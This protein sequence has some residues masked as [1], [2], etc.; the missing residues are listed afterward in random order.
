MKALQISKPGKWGEETFPR[1]SHP[2]SGRADAPVQVR[3]RRRQL[4]LNAMVGLLLLTPLIFGALLGP[5]IAPYPADEMN[6]G[7]RLHAPSS[8]YPFGTD[9]FGRDLFSRVLTG[10]RTAAGMALGGIAISTLLGT[11]LGLLAGYYGGW[12][13]HLLS[14]AMDTWLAFPGL[15][16]AIIIVAR[17]GPSLTN[18]IIALGFMEVPVLYRV[19]RG[20]TLSVRHALYVEA[21]RAIGMTDRR[22]LT[23]HILPDLYSPITVLCTLHMGT[24]LLA[25]SGLSFIGLGAQPPQPEWG[26]LLSSGRRYMAQAWWLTFFPGMAIML[27][28][29]GFNLLG[30][31]LRDLLDPRLRTRR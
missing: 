25:G 30:D 29:L 21:A 26:L 20:T 19:A 8:Q 24:I 31:G 14:R 22:L 13:D 18:A 28:V 3:R 12:L 7:P 4:P 1:P 15:L 23:R 9:A 17:L 27:S 11:L 6:V 2:I 10:A 5:Q 16:M